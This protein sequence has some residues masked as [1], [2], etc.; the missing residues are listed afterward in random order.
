MGRLPSSV[1][2]R[3]GTDLKRTLRVGGPIGVACLRVDGAC[4]CALSGERPSTWRP[5]YPTGVSRGIG[6]GRY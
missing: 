2:E 1:T 6:F 3:L 5:C 4:V